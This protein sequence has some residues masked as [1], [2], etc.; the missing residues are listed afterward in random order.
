MA[1]RPDGGGRG[2]RVV[3]RNGAPVDVHA[4]VRTTPKSPPRFR[5]DE[6]VAANMPRTTRAVDHR[7][8]RR[9]R[10][11]HGWRRS[12]RTAAA[13]T[14]IRCSNGRWCTNSQR[15]RHSP[16]VAGA[17]RRRH[18]LARPALRRAARQ[19]VAA[20]KPKSHLIL[21][22]ADD[23]DRVRRGERHPAHG[24][25]ICGGWRLD[26]ANRP[27]QRRRVGRAAFDIPHFAMERR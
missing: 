27:R 5:G 19:V 26:S 17:P 20:V 4:G 7:R 13:S 23:F 25:S 3:S 6:L 18:Y 9:R 1:G 22:S 11:G 24:L 10:C 15:G 2:R 21:V 14:A 12:A 8:D 16:R